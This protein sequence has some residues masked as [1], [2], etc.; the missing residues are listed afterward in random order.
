MCRGDNRVARALWRPRHH[1]AMGIFTSRAGRVI[2]AKWPAAGQ[3][4]SRDFTY[5]PAAPC[6]IRC[7]LVGAVRHARRRMAHGSA[8]LVAAA[9]D[10]LAVAAVR[11]CSGD[12]VTAGLFS[13]V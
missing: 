1:R 8:A 5:W 10:F 7:M 12:V 2:G 3:R 13:R 4:R 11:G 9:R 6:A